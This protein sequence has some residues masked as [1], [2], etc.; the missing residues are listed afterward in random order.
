M[1]GV[2]RKREAQAEAEN[3][4]VVDPERPVPAKRDDDPEVRKTQ[5]FFGEVNKKVGEVNDKARLSLGAT[6]IMSRTGLL[7]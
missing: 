4:P 5:D 3:K 2:G 6:L 7:I 1:D